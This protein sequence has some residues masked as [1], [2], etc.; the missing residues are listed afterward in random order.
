MPET[1]LNEKFARTVEEF[2]F[3]T[4]MLML[5]AAIEAVGSGEP[6]NAGPSVISAGEAESN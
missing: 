1:G 2:A 3:H 6:Q 4:D 5:N